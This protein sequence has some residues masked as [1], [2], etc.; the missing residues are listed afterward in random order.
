M[1]AVDDGLKIVR[2]YGNNHSMVGNEKNYKSSYRRRFGHYPGIK[3]NTG[4]FIETKLNVIPAVNF[5]FVL[6]VL[7]IPFKTFQGPWD[8]NSNWCLNSL[9]S[10]H[11]E[12]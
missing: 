1:I 7:P 3:S 2:N 12:N 6:D 8:K 9:S 10:S 4:F 5:C 11:Y